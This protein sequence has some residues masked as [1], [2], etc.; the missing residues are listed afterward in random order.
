[1]TAMLLGLAACAGLGEPP[2][3]NT[4]SGWASR[5]GVRLS[6]AEVEALKGSC[7]PRAASGPLDSA[8]PIANPI[9]DNPIYRPGGEGFAN[10]PFNGINADERPLQLGF[11]RIAYNSGTIDACLIEKGLVPITPNQRSAILR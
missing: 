6:I 9:R 2:V 1:M 5:S 10:A 7:R 8:D 11:R 4:G 3:V